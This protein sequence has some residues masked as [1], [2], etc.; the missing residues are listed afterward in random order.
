MN[1]P[2]DWA[3]WAGFGETAESA[4]SDREH[5]RLLA[6]LDEHVR[7]RAS[8]YERPRLSQERLPS[9]QSEWPVMRSIGL[10]R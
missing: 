9:V 4:D 7:S 3:S 5:K 1:D 6:D 10:P 2:D 8:L